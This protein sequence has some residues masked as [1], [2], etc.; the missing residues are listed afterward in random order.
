[1]AQNMAT[2]ICDEQPDVPKPESVADLDSFSMVQVLLEM[3][4]T[5]G[6]NLLERFEGF[7]GKLFTDLAAF[8][9]RIAE[10]EGVLE[11]L[12]EVSAVYRPENLERHVDG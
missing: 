2:M 12:D 11:R 9:V 8:V 3:E 7:N 1:M 4:N 6:L 10:E 5:T